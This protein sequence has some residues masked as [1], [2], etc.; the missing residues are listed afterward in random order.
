MFTKQLKYNVN[1][2]SK[3]NFEEKLIQNYVTILQIL[4]CLVPTSYFEYK[5]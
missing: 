4:R 3:L 2:R 1:P 5:L